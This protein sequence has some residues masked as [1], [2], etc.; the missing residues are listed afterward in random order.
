MLG[1]PDARHRAELIE[2]L[3]RFGMDPGLAMRSF[4]NLNRHHKRILQ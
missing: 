3:L 2:L 1:V 4:K